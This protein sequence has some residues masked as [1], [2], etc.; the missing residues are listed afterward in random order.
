MVTKD[1]SQ[2]ILT[3]YM[4]ILFLVVEYVRYMYFIIG[5]NVWSHYVTNNT[6]MHRHK[7][8]GDSYMVKMH[9]S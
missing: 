2:R 5:P 1:Y 7:V 6:T 4:S 3:Y 8:T 9:F